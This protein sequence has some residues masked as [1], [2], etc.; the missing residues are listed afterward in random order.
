MLM[1]APNL[2]LADLAPLVEY[3]PADDAYVFPP[4]PLW[5]LACGHIDL[6]ATDE[7][8]AAVWCGFCG[9]TVAIAQEVSGT[10][11]P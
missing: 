11:G 3:I 2:D 7:T 9:T 5:L 8:P 10:V 4:E 1:L 6:P